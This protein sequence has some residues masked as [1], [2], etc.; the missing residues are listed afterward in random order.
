MAAAP[1][2]HPEG[3]AA[4]DHAKHE[5]LHDAPFATDVG[6]GPRYGTVCD[7]T[8]NR[9]AFRTVSGTQDRRSAAAP[10]EQQAPAAVEWW[11]LN[12]VEPGTGHRV[13]PYVVNDGWLYDTTSETVAVPRGQ[14]NL[15]VRRRSMQT[16][17][18]STACPTR[19]TPGM[20]E[21][22]MRP[23]SPTSTC[24]SGWSAW[25]CCSPSPS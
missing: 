7:A 5:V 14:W 23:P 12:A 1:G 19:A 10:G 3:A 15:S 2:C 8:T 21:A 18:C 22:P 9:I 20:S 16:P 4:L 25:W 24:A 17:Y 6:A 13:G 11:A